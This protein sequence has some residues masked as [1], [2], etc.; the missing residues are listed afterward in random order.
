M[1]AVVMFTMVILLVLDEPEDSACTP[2]EPAGSAGGSASSPGTKVAPM[3]SGTY[4]LSSGYG[5]REGGEFHRGV[6]FAAPAGTP[7]YAAADGVAAHA[8]PADGFGSWIVIDHNIDGSAVSTVYGHMFAEDL[9]VS[10]G[11]Q[12]K[13]G[14]QIAL[15]GYAG[16][17]VPDGPQGAHLHF[18]TWVGGLSGEAEDPALWLADASEPGAPS[19]RPDGPE[20]SVG[21]DEQEQ[22]AV[23][24]PAAG[25]VPEGAPLPPPAPAIDS[26]ENLQLDAIRVAR[27]VAAAFPEIVT[28]GGWREF[29]QFPDHPS[30]RAVDVMIPD[31]ASGQGKA[32]GDRVADF[33]MANAE[34]LRVE[35]IIWRQE[36]RPVNGTPLIMEDR[37]GD[38]AN[39]MDHVHV[40]VIGGGYPDGSTSDDPSNPVAADKGCQVFDND[41]LKPGA[42]PPAFEHWYR[43]AGALCPQ[44]SA[45]LLAAQGMQ[46]S[47]FDP[48]VSSEAGA[49]GL[50]QFLP[51]TAASIN[52][53]DGRPYV[54]DADGNGTASVWDPGDAIMGQGRYM[55]AIADK[56][57]AWIAEGKVVAP[58][59][60]TELYLAAY[61][62]GEGAVL[63]SGGFPTGASDYQVQTR[64]YVDT[65][66]ATAAQY[67]RMDR[68]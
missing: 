29:D 25:A 45:S 11:E 16:V 41:D 5:I 35:Y 56:V 44:I 49:Q 48:N 23:D 62:A 17:T 19:P 61:N 13:A 67:R 58:N 42:V 20:S 51:G 8:G 63:E 64:P 7:I 26:E 32:L 30:G 3:R 27:T 14:Q 47:K 54:I 6:D 28:I 65:I 21:F 59:G 53:D 55:C 4:R 18:E 15:V 24:V 52:P 66:L 50:A 39:H 57:D 9:H 1:T 2:A 46:E 43:Q 31:Y 22:A 40:T 10:V 33:V 38:T 60:R 37:W 68:M 12:V 34:Q 36:Y